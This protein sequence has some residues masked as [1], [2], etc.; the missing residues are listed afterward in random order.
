MREGRGG[1]GKQ[2]KCSTEIT[3]YIIKA[4][5]LKNPN[6]GKKGEQSAMIYNYVSVYIWKIQAHKLKQVYIYIWLSL[7]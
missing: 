4:G 7:I 5:T 6:T 3:G 1:E 2:K